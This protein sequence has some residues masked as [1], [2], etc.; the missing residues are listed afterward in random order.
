MGTIDTGCAD[1]TST[2]QLCWSI[3]RGIGGKILKEGPKVKYECRCWVKGSASFAFAN[4]KTKSRTG[5]LENC[6]KK[7]EPKIK[8]N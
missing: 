6:I 3:D 1:L 2:A 7:L 8:L 5:A 4:A